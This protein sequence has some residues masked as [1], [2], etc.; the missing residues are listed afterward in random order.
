[1]TVIAVALA[2]V[3]P[4]AVVH[5]ASLLL[6]APSLATFARD[7]LAVTGRLGGRDDGRARR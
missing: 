1:M 7:Y 6:V 5:P 3:L 4:T 2:P